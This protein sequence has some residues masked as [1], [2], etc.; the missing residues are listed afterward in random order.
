[1]DQIKSDLNYEEMKRQEKREACKSASVQYIL[2]CVSSILG[3]IIGMFVVLSSLF[4][5]LLIG[6]LGLS[7]YFW[8]AVSFI[9]CIFY[10][11][12]LCTLKKHERGFLTAGLTYIFYMILYSLG[13]FAFENEW[14]GTLL[15][16]AGLIFGIIYTYNLVAST[17]DILYGVNNRL[18]YAWD[19]Y[20]KF[21][22]VLLSVSIGSL[23]L[24]LVPVI[25]L[26]AAAVVLILGIV[27]IFINIWQIIL[28]IL[29]T[30]ALRKF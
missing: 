26:I 16:F 13:R 18:A 19:T 14:V 3:I 24:F 22:T 21:I 10:G 6:Y 1:M 29:T 8:L 30:V 2:L 28:L 9:N 23:L 17:G 4:Y 5:R 27:L 15:M 7:L 11:V 25:N 12:V 20:R